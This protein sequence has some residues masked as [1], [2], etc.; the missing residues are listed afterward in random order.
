MVNMHPKLVP[1]TCATAKG[2]LLKRIAYPLV[3]AELN[4]S[5][6]SKFPINTRVLHEHR[7]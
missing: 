7:L 6:R 2:Y 3:F 4:D 1:G 5:L